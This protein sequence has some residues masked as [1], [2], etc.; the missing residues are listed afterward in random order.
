MATK[1]GNL[2]LRRLAVQIILVLLVILVVIREF[3]NPI[4][5]AV[6]FASGLLLVLVAVDPVRTHPLYPVAFGIV[7]AL[8]GVAGIVV[9]SGIDPLSVLLILG[10]LAVIAEWGY[11]RFISS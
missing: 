8:S 3:G 6:G 2:S 10:G 1:Q 4:F 5:A 11:G 7:I 9:N